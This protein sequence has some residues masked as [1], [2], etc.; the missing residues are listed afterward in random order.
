MGLKNW[1]EHRFSASSG[2]DHWAIPVFN[3]V[4][5]NS[6]FSVLVRSLAN[7]RLSPNYSITQSDALN[8][9]ITAVNLSFVPTEL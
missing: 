7:T 9:S 2:R 4:Q 5:F 3:S 8:I 1:Q 6:V